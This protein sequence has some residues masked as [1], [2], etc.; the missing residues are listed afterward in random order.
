MRRF[1]RGFAQPSARQKLNRTTRRRASGNCKTVAAFV[2]RSEDHLSCFPDV[3]SEELSAVAQEPRVWRT[4]PAGTALHDP[5][6]WRSLP[7]A[8][9][10]RIW[11]TKPPA[12][13]LCDPD[14]LVW[15]PSY[16]SHSFLS[17]PLPGAP[18]Q[19]S[20]SSKTELLWIVLRALLGPPRFSVPN[21]LTCKLPTAGLTQQRQ[22]V[23]AVI[24]GTPTGMRI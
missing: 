22:G 20:G 15:H 2:T 7:A 12:T 23:V 14:Q 18:C 5:G 4:K 10:L 9:E 3:C 24:R 1:C 21:L 17:E 11:G 16:R 6:Q 8:Q 13:A 19:R